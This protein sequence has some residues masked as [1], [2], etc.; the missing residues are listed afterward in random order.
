MSPVTSKWADQERQR[1]HYRTVYTKHLQVLVIKPQT[2]VITGR[3]RAMRKK[4]RKQYSRY[5]QAVKTRYEGTNLQPYSSNRRY[6]NSQHIVL[7]DSVRNN[8]Q[9]IM[10]IFNVSCNKEEGII[11]YFQVLQHLNL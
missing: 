8:S 5:T 11:A 1:Q 4:K 3:L 10:N 2:A 9:L 7:A 6:G